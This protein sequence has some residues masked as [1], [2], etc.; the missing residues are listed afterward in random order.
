MSVVVKYSL[1]A[2]LGLALVG[3]AL[4]LNIA[5]QGGGSKLKDG[6]R[7][8]DVEIGGLSTEEAIAALQQKEENPH[9]VLVKIS[10]KSWKISAAKLG[11]SIDE[12]ASLQPVIE[13]NQSLNWADKIRAFFKRDQDL[14]DQQFPIVYQIDTEKARIVLNDLAQKVNQEPKN[15]MVGFSN[16]RLRYIVTKPSVTGM[17]ANV[18]TAVAELE[19]N[20]NLTSLNVPYSTKEATHSTA[21][22]KKL[23]DK[24][25]KMM[26]PMVFRLGNSERTG[27]LNR[28]QVANLY[29][30]KQKGI[31]L[32]EKTL[33]RAYKKITGY[34]NQPARGARYGWRG[35]EWGKVGEKNGLIADPKKSMEIFKK[36]L[37]DPTQ[38]EVVFP[39][40]QE[41]P[42][43]TLASLPRLGEVQLIATGVS[44][45]YG[46]SPERRANI[47]NAAKKIDGSVVAH[48]DNFS[49]LNSLGGITRSNGFI[50]GL[51]IKDGRTVDGLGGGVC[52]VSTTTFRAMYQA[53]LPVVERN[54]HSYRV[55]YYEPR[56]GFEAAVYDP[57]LDLRMK[58]DTG[59]TM[60]IRTVNNNRKST[61]TVQIWGVKPQRTVKIS[62]AVILASQPHPPAKYVDNPQLKRGVVKQVD[63][64]A[65]GYTLY[66]TRVIKDANGKVRKDRIDTKYKPWQAIFERGTRG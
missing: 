6:F 15:G 31:L 52:Q 12:K 55:K 36:A 49:F 40:I 22:L 5:A 19:K 33:Q 58:N 23:V 20:P 59:S 64:A 4:A 66:I 35:K 50:G 53:G 61:L 63:W 57:G 51:V 60:V 24:G 44:T 41:V 46:S 27:K 32:D 62:K 17:W 8:G 26:R 29:W 38:T 39:A 34:I 1:I 42:Q 28:L 14:K 25:N 9:Q 3:G 21:K 7:V 45:Y 37:L 10:N 11:W 48:G 2:V 65:N 13:V 16:R 47:A 43:V 56:V 18:N 30:V 54:Q